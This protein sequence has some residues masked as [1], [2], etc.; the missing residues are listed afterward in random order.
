LGNELHT[1][2]AKLVD[3]ARRQLADT[4]QAS[5][6]SL[7]RDVKAVSEEWRGELAQTVSKSAREATD[8]LNLAGEQ[9]V[10]KLQ[11]AQEEAAA[12]FTND[13]ERAR[14]RLADL[15]ASGSEEIQRTA[16]S[17]LDGF[18][19][20][21]KEKAR[22]TSGQAGDQLREMLQQL[23]ASSLRESESKHEDLV[24]QQRKIFQDNIDLASE[25]T[26][27][28][29]T[30]KLTGL[31]QEQRRSLISRLAP[32]VLALVPAILFVYFSTRP[33]RRLRVDPPAKFVN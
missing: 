10:A 26:L 32:V 7:L 11:T 24:K 14:E 21:L 29:I 13:A 3:E 30:Q 16:D 20:S 6:E 31:E 1:S 23:A 12:R 25:A 17:V 28:R 33:V 5:Q 27:R 22:A 8:S 15:S 2:G 19:H 9:A 4:A 18:S